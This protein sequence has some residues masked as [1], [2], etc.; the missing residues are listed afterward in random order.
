MGLGHASSDRPQMVSHREE[1]NHA[2]DS[3]IMARGPRCLI[4]TW[5]HLVAYGVLTR[6]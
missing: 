6:H 5:G 2:S 4:L 3:E 1:M